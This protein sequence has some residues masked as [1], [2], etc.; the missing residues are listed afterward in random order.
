MAST[1]MGREVGWDREKQEEGNWNQNIGIKKIYFP[2]KEKEKLTDTGIMN[3]GLKASSLVTSVGQTHQIWPVMRQN[4]RL[5]NTQLF[6]QR[7][8]AGLTSTY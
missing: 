6:E 7:W 4:E 8:E 5:M 2:I 1:Q 3:L